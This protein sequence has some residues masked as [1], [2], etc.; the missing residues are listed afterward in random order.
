[1]PSLV[2]RNPLSG[3]ERTV[4]MK[5]VTKQEKYIRTTRWQ[6]KTEWRIGDLVLLQAK[7]Y[8]TAG[9]NSS[10][11]NYTIITDESRIIELQIR[12]DL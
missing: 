4:D 1:M 6:N 3:E 5:F 2:L 8:Q 9:H 11:C 7:D 12:T 10:N